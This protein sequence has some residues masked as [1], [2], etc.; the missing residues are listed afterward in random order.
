M[1]PRPYQTERQENPNGS[2]SNQSDVGAKIAAA[3]AIVAHLALLF[4][5]GRLGAIGAG[6]RPPIH[7]PTI[8]YVASRGIRR[9]SGLAACS[10]Q[11]STREDFRFEASITRAF[12][13]HE[14]RI[15]TMLGRTPLIAARLD[16]TWRNHCLDEDA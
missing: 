6:E 7:L 4:C 9:R 11:T 8:A 5:G 16:I 12:P 14:P 10:V 13:R 2:I 1:A 3:V 15:A